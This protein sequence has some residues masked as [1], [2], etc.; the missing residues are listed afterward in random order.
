MQAEKKFALVT[1]GSNIL[2]QVVV[3]VDQRFEMRIIAMMQV[4]SSGDDDNDVDGN[5]DDDEDDDEADNDGNGVGGEAIRGMRVLSK[6]RWR[7]RRRRWEQF[8][9]TAS[10]LSGNVGR[11]IY[12]PEPRTS[13]FIPFSYFRFEGSL[14]LL[15]H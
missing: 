2:Y 9:L 1:D 3:V 11:R 4:A 8:R 5:G 12:W 13:Q 7:R 14:S 15:Q 10:Q 6:R